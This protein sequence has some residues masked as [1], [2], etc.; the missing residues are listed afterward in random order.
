MYNNI[1]F[2]VTIGL[3]ELSFSA[4]ENSSAKVCVSLIDIPLS[5]Q[6]GYKFNVSITTDEPGAGNTIFYEF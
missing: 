3:E 2:L 5:Y 4:T 6:D 1:P